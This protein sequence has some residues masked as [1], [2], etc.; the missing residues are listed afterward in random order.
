M[1]SISVSHCIVSVA[2]SLKIQLICK[3]GSQIVL[4]VFKLRLFQLSN[5]FTVHLIQN[6]PR[7]NN[8]SQ[9]IKSLKSHDSDLFMSNILNIR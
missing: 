9:N 6:L 2:D 8:H 7:S 1:E 4:R 5:F 3:I